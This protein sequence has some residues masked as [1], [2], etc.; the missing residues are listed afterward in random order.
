MVHGRAELLTDGQEA[1]ESKRVT[2]DLLL[3]GRASAQCPETLP[4]TGHGLVGHLKVLPAAG[5]LWLPS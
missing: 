1:R 2:V 5:P 3:L 4:T